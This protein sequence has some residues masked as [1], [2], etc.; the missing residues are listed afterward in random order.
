MNLRIPDDA[1][2]VW[3]AINELKTKD[4]LSKLSTSDL[5]IVASALKTLIRG[6]KLTDS[7]KGRV[8]D[9]ASDIDEGSSSESSLGKTVSGFDSV[10]R[11]GH[12]EEAKEKILGKIATRLE[13][14]NN[15][16]LLKV[17]E[18]NL[19]KPIFSTSS[20]YTL[21]VAEQKNVMKK[22]IQQLNHLPDSER[23]QY[24]EY[25][26]LLRGSPPRTEDEKKKFQKIESALPMFRSAEK[27]NIALNSVETTI[28]GLKAGDRNALKALNLDR[29]ATP[30][31]EILDE[32]KTLHKDM[33][34]FER[35]LEKMATPEGKKETLESLLERYKQAEISLEPF[36]GNPQIAS[37]FSTVLKTE[38]RLINLTSKDAGSESTGTKAQ[39]ATLMER[40]AV[41]DRYVAFSKE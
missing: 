40:A 27:E 30:D 28:K 33:Q 13:I 2:Q 24:E 16:Q 21:D 26:T 8:L 20:F 10:F 38:A 3:G 35:D 22:R 6:E 19:T 39:V 5:K 14:V 1:T 36:A 34:T 4:Q 23:K 9:I 12:Q 25:M 11:P 31:E 15:A 32:L 7:V 37:T 41:W 18:N 17:L 29:S